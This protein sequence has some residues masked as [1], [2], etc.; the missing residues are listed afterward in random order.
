MAK[1]QAPGSPDRSQSAP[2]GNAMGLTEAFPPVSSD[3]FTTVMAAVDGSGES[4]VEGEE[5]VAGSEG[6]LE[7]VDL[8]DGA[9]L[10]DEGLPAGESFGDEEAFDDFYAGRP[11]HDERDIPEAKPLAVI[12]EPAVTK[13]A[14]KAKGAGPRHGRHASVPAE[15]DGKPAVPEYMRKSRRMRRILIVVILLLIVLLGAMFYFGYQM[16]K[17]SDSTA[18][19]QAQ[20][21]EQQ[22]DA[23]GT[24]DAT[25]A[26]NEAVKTTTVPDLVS[27]LGL[28]QD[29]AVA[30][31]QHGAQVTGEPR[32]VN[33][34][35]NPIKTELRVALTA[36]PADSR[37][38]TPTVF[39]GL[40]KKGKIIQAGYSTSTASLGYGALSF[41]DA[42]RTE[43]VIEKTLAEAGVTVADGD[44]ALPE[45]SAAYTTY[46]TD[47]KTITKEYCSF[48]GSSEVDGAPHTWSAVL[49]YDYSMANASGNLADTV[50]T[51]F[52]YV[53]S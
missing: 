40:N 53:N 52:V 22:V 25:D 7:E 28:T 19:Q 36:E 38:G 21:A 30:L 9:P 12:S 34:E 14:P 37:T 44:V 18:V 39:L 16:L 46:D 47:G 11:L 6:V 10:D 20:N 8:A 33:E 49:S 15:K 27:L 51:I 35:G 5:I 41:A 13:P 43:H 1:K 31:L 48:S 26:A 4:S 42:V 17:T 3:G 45:D 24:D 2:D 32:A 23:I 50:R 29:E